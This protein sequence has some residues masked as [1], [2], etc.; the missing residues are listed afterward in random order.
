MS[1]QKTLTGARLYLGVYNPATGKTS[2]KGSFQSISW[3]LNYTAE[4]IYTLGNFGP[5]EIVYTSQ[6]AIS[7][8]GSMWHSF[9]H[10][11]HAEA[12]IPAL[13]SLLLYE[14]LELV[15]TDKQAEA[16]GKDGRVAKF[17]GVVPLGYQTSV[18]SRQTKEITVT[19]MALRVDDESVT[20]A[21]S[22]GSPNLP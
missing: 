8:T 11:A 14:N 13:Q 20:N 4:P 5:K 2:I 6:D 3:G 9:E 18:S 19:F 1:L 10:G 21:E 12:E 16:Q 15:L 22:P 7:I 17:R